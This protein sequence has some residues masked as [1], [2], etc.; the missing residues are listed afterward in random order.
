MVARNNP[1][2]TKESES[3]DASASGPRR[4]SEA[5]APSTT[6]KIG[7]THGDKS[8]RMR[9]INASNGLPMVM[10]SRSDGLAEQRVDRRAIRVAYRSTFFL[11]SL[12]RYQGRLHTGAETIDQIL[13]A[14]EI[15]HEIDQVLEFRV[16]SQF[17]ENGRL[18]LA[19]RAPGGVDCDEDRFAS[20]LCVGEGLAIK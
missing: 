5:A 3:P 20:L 14:I 6:G 17:A 4:C 12:E 15:D 11:G 7:S 13:L 1:R 16:R 2:T 19:G 9:A 18:R 10:V 8:E